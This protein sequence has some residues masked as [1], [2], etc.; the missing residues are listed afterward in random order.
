MDIR[1]EIR[2]ELLSLRDEKYRDFN[3][4]LIPGVDDEFIG[5]KTP[6]LK[7]LAKKLSKREDIR[8]FLDDLP[9]HSFEENQ[10][11]AFIICQMKDYDEAMQETETFLP[12]IN[13]WAT[14]DQLSP[15]AFKKNT[16]DLDKRIRKWMKSEKTYTIRFGIGMAMRYFLDEEY[17]PAYLKMVSRIRS[18]EYYV[19]MMVAWYFATALAKQYDDAIIYLEEGKLDPWVHNKTISKATESYRIS[20]EQKEYLR[21]LKIRKEK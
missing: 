16:K 18:D 10:L 13:N 15:K 12:Y 4:S 2:K 6:E 19:K 5:V 20:D 1:K 21:S 9:H 7:A 14:C 8:D 3:H 17:D 11:H